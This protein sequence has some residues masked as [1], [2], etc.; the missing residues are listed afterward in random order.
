MNQLD[1]PLEVE[2]NK[3]G[4]CPVCG[5]G[6][7]LQGA[8]GWTCDYFHTLEDKCSFT[9]FS[10]YDG[11]E[12]MEEDAKAL[13]TIGQTEEKQFYTLAGKP[14]R[15]ILKRAGSQIKVVGQ[16]D[17][18]KNN[19][20]K[21]GG[22][23]RELKNG[24]ACEH[25]F[26][27]GDNHCTFWVHKTMCNREISKEEVEELITK[28]YTE[29][30]D[31]FFAQ[32]KYFSS[33]IVLDKEKGAILNADICICPKCG[34]RV[35]AGIKAYNCSNYRNPSVKCDFVI[36]RNLAGHR[37]KVKEVR[38]LCEEGKSDLMT[39]FSKE[40]SPYT[41]R[42]IIDDNGNVKMV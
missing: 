16:G 8:A 27:E 22:R 28:H 1:L 17:Y 33:C 26:E 6:Q 5:K 12:L 42:L 23:V 21:C 3:I 34:G 36:W 7:M 30:L 37:M 38:G 31:G 2:L 29:V 11:Y 14:F 20:P 13:I 24:Y 10:V 41:R 19:C 18:L 15:G 39:F 35:F 25:F 40:G 9:I 32:G 4:E